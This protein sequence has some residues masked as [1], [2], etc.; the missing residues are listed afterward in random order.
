MFIGFIHGLNH[1]SASSRLLMLMLAQ[2]AA[3]HVMLTLCAGR[4]S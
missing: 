1:P 2:T 3:P 4:A